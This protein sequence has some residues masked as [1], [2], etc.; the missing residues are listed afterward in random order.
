MK[1]V[2]LSVVKAV[3]SADILPR[4]AVSTDGPFVRNLQKGFGMQARTRRTIFPGAVLRCSA[5]RVAHL[6]KVRVIER[7]CCHG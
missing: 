4:C 5:E 1:A 3:L 6:Q 2:C 7:S